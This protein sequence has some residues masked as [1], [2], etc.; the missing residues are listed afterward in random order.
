MRV[1]VGLVSSV[2]L[3]AAPVSAAPPMAVALSS[4]SVMPRV[5]LV[6]MV[7]DGGP[8]AGV[9]VHG[10][11][12]STT[13]YVVKTAKQSG[14]CIVPPYSLRLTNESAFESTNEDDEASFLV[15]LVRTDGKA[16][17]EKQ[18]FSFDPRSGAF[19]AGARVSVALTEVASADGVVVWAYREGPHVVLVTRGYES[20]FDSPRR[21]EDDA[22]QFVGVDGCPYGLARLDAGAAQAGASAELV[23]SMPTQGKGKDAVTPRFIVDAS[24]ARLSRD[25][26]PVLTVR[27]RVRTKD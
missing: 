10:V 23:G 13:W 27:V 16:M 12:P 24:L 19:A 21:R 22:G 8:P 7:K 6:P 20:G 15:H 26:E 3:V 2:L 14:L 9:S 25:P 18:R 1:L 5:P 11:D 17:L 4:L